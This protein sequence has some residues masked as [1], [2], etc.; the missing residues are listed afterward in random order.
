MSSNQRCEIVYV[1]RGK[2]SGWQWRPT[3]SGAR[4]GANAETYALFYECVQ[5]ARVSGYSPANLKCS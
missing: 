3:G 1:K 4:P 2:A 5:A